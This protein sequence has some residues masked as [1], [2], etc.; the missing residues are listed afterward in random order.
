MYVVVSTLVH[1]V[2]EGEDVSYIDII[3]YISVR[4]QEN[5]PSPVIAS[6]CCTGKF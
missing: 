6:S 3:W 1:D 4:H 5:T 2:C